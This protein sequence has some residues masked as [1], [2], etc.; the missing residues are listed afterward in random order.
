MF[1]ENL[2]GVEMYIKNQ[3]SRFNIFKTAA[4]DKKKVLFLNY[5]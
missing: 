3:A 1:L 5:L 4:F 2:G